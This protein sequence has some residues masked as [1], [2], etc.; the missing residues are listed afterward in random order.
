VA[1]SDYWRDRKSTYKPLEIALCLQQQRSL[2]RSLGIKADITIGNLERAF[3]ASVVSRRLISLDRS[4]FECDAPFSGEMVDLITGV[5]IHEH[6]RLKYSFPSNPWLDPTERLVMNLFEDR[7]IDRKLG[8]EK[9]AIFF[10]CYLNVLRKYI[11]APE[12]QALAAKSYEQ[13]RCVETFC[14]LAFTE[15]V[16]YF[17]DEKTKEAA[18]ILEDGYAEYEGEEDEFRRVQVVRR[19]DN[20]LSGL[21][22]VRVAEHLEELPGE[23]FLFLAFLLKGKVNALPRELARDVE[24]M[25]H[26]NADEHSRRVFGQSVLVLKAAYDTERYNKYL[27]QVE[28]HI[29]KL[30]VRSRSLSLGRVTMEE[31]GRPDR[32]RLWRAVLGEENVFT[33]WRLDERRY[34]SFALALVLD[35]SDSISNLDCVLPQSV[36]LWESLRDL[37]PIKVY[38]YQ[39]SNPVVI[40]DLTPAG[41]QL[42]LGEVS[43]KGYTPSAI[44]LD[45]ARSFFAHLR[46]PAEKVLIHLT[47]GVPNVEQERIPAL[48]DERRGSDVRMLH[49]GVGSLN[50]ESMERYYGRDY[51]SAI[52]F[53]TVPTTITQFFG[54]Q[55]E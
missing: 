23:L 10:R 28:P 17:A 48:L 40:W 25:Q 30:R 24:L 33:R 31:F 18:R 34:G 7:R 32:Q 3:G 37:G 52:D 1:Y 43:V 47:D 55:E 2:L 11:T 5:T 35:V 36:L 39:G 9:E 6:G 26:A 21:F 41:G 49:L 44:G 38:G 14:Y 19:C 8:R 15:A 46:L 45:F 50:R 13:C 42:C 29:R 4:L 12:L 22:A 54:G 16:S 27:S 53:D 51:R 20:M